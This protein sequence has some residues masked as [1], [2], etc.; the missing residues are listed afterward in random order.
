M[1]SPGYLAEVNAEVGLKFVF[2]PYRK[3]NPVPTGR[4]NRSSTRPEG[5][6]K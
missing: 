1:M 2:G 3:P 6:Q 5:S 4:L